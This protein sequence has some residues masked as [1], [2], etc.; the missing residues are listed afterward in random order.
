MFK[1][2][3]LTLLAILSLAG[4]LTAQAASPT[5]NDLQAQIA[6]LQP[7]ITALQNAI[8]NI[9]VSGPKRVQYRSATSNQ[10]TFI[11]PE[12]AN[13]TNVVV[14]N[15]L[16]QIPS[17]P[18]TDALGNPYKLATSFSDTVPQ[19]PAGDAPEGTPEY[20]AIYYCPHI[21]G[22]N[23]T[24]NFP[25]SQPVK[26]TAMEFSGLQGIIDPGSPGSNNL[27]ILK[28]PNDAIIGAQTNYNF[29]GLLI[30]GVYFVN[31]PQNGIGEYPAYALTVVLY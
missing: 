15:G 22:G 3:L 30:P 9:G 21:V 4:A 24:I 5:V 28:N 11:N 7:Q 17:A 1:K 12:T 16:G 8:K 23:N 31:D 26:I 6:A 27:V 19:Y 18:P 13:D 14:V 10:V 2:S 29:A 20:T 25:A